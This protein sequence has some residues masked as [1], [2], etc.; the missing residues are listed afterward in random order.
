MPVP[1][2]E[3]EAIDIDGPP[4]APRGAQQPVE[5]QKART[6]HPI[7]A[8]ALAAQCRAGGEEQRIVE[9]PDRRAA[10]AQPR[11]EFGRPVML[12]SRP[13]LGQG[14]RAASLL[15]SGID[16][17]KEALRV[18]DRGA[19]VEA[20]ILQPLARL[21][22]EIHENEMGEP[23]PRRAAEALCIVEADHPVRPVHRRADPPRLRRIADHGDAARP[24][25][26][27]A[28]R[29]MAR[30]GSAAAGG[31]RR[32]VVQKPPRFERARRARTR[33]TWI[34]RSGMAGIGVC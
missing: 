18:A 17:Q 4:H 5:R 24:V 9:E 33:Q 19:A 20:H 11:A 23:A 15:D 25:G 30:R 2:G 29:P 28:I 1:A 10:Q 32:D 14:R 6:R 31:E 26:C 7:L 27:G 12:A 34:G 3:A 22:A 16:R 8:P 21:P 13:L